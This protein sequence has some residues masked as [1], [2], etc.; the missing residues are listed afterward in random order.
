MRITGQ[1]PGKALPYVEILHHFL[2]KEGV[3]VAQLLDCLQ[4]IY[5]YNPWLPEERI[6]DKE[7]KIESGKILKR[8][9]KAGQGI[10]VQF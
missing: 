10:P 4:V 1:K 7:Y 3:Q 2:K 5:N 8:H 6:L 9:M